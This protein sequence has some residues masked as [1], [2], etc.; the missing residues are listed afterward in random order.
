MSINT[1]DRESFSR[2]ETNIHGM[3]IPSQGPPNQLIMY[4]Y[5][6]GWVW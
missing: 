6:G 3:C 4:E 5:T 1:E 2:E